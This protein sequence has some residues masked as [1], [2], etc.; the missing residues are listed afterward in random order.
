[1]STVGSPDGSPNVL[2][3]CLDDFDLG[4][5][6]LPRQF[7]F[8]E[9]PHMDALA[10]S[11][12]RLSDG[13]AAAPVCSSS[14]ASL[15]TGKTPAR[16]G[17]TDGIDIVASGDV[18]A[19]QLLPPPSLAHLSGQEHTLAHCLAG[20]GYQCWHVGKWHVGDDRADH[21]PLQAGF[22]V[23]IG[24]HHYSTPP[25]GYFAPWGITSLDDPVSPQAGAESVHL[26]DQLTQEALRLIAE[27]DV[28][29]I[30]FS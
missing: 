4:G 9:T 13:Y 28:D 17:L 7:T 1:M 23:N 18:H 5:S 27:R 3:I 10:A 20:H 16:L 30:R 26:T 24:G 19:G 12:V 2:V 21:G 29:Q 15:L 11:G 8:Y 14:C 22:A 6:W 25:Q